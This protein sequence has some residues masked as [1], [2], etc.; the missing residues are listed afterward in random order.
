MKHASPRHRRHQDVQAEPIVVAVDGSPHSDAAIAWAAREGALRTAA[1]T[2]VH[3]VAPMVNTP[4]GGAAKTTVDDR[5]TADGHAV[6]AAAE[7]L[8]RADAPD[9]EVR[10]TIL[11]APVLPALIDASA[12]AQL[13]AVGSR[14]HGALERLLM[15]SVST[16]LVHH[17]QC[18]VAVIPGRE[19]VPNRHP[20]LLGVDA[21]PASERAI[22]VA[23]EEAAQRGADLVALHAWS[24]VGI[25]PVVGTDRWYAYEADVAARLA[26]HLAPW[27]E[28]YPDAHLTRRVVCDVAAHALFF[29]SRYAQLVVVGSRGQGGFVGLQLGSV[30]SAIVHASA[31]PVIVVR[32][33]HSDP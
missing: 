18:P 33:H 22:A 25:M 8:F 32:Q 6:L 7:A 10:T 26:E 31:T 23:F 13:I 28:K 4:L 11:V 30:A 16:G 14:G 5:L 27:Q 20:V 21:A 3:V 9:V 19:T 2:L 1:V 17:A 29:E 15:G 24:D 12:G